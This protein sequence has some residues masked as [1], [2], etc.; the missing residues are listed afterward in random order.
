M[1]HREVTPIR[2]AIQRQYMI[3]QLLDEIEAD[4]EHLNIDIDIPSTRMDINNVILDLANIVAEMES[5][6]N[7]RYKR[8]DPPESVE[9]CAESSHRKGAC[10]IFKLEGAGG[11][12]A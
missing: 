11:Y 5:H 1:Y 6:P 12:T 8:L 2:A 3:L 4:P 9:T 10:F 7:F